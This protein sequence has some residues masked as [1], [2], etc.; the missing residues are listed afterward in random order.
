[1]RAIPLV[2]LADWIKDT[3]KADAANYSPALAVVQFTDYLNLPSTIQQIGNRLPAVLVEVDFSPF[4]RDASATD[5][6][7]QTYNFRLHYLHALSDTIGQWGVGAAACS[8]L[9]GTFASDED[10]D[11]PG[12]TLPEGAE[13]EWVLPT[14]IDR[15]EDLLDHNLGHW[16]VTVEMALHAL[17]V[18]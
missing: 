12:L 6:L 18:S 2:E 4:E 1:M 9:A 3:V 17:P 11:A 7:R 8:R 13:L 14:G 15:L 10:F 16:T 5:G